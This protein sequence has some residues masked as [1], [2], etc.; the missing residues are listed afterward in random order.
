M[1]T[2]LSRRVAKL[3]GDGHGGGCGITAIIR[4]YVYPGDG[5]RGRETSEAKFNEVTLHRDPGELAA[6][7][8]ARAI[9]A[10]KAATPSG[11]ARINFF[12]EPHAER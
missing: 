5:P 4:R 12:G 10:A 1:S 7:F 2:P 3:E 11:I 8:E 9:A 6:D